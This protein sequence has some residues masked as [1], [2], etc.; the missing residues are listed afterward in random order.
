MP[1]PPCLKAYITWTLVLLLSDARDS[2]FIRL[3]HPPPPHDPPP[4][5]IDVRM[6]YPQAKAPCVSLN[7]DRQVNASGSG[8][9]QPLSVVVVDVDVVTSDN[10]Y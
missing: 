5:P 1:P 7:C 2:A 10:R 6:E 8:S 4:P 9:C 3:Y